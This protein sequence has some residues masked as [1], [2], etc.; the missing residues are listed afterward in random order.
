VIIKDSIHQAAP[1]PPSPEIGRGAG[2]EGTLGNVS[3]I[4]TNAKIRRASCHR[5]ITPTH[6]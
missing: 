2:G 1:F 5:K 6:S 4:D 3:T